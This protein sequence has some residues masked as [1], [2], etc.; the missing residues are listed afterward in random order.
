MRMILEDGDWKCLLVVTFHT[1]LVWS[2]VNSPMYN[3]LY[4]SENGFLMCM[5]GSL[6]IFSPHVAISVVDNVLMVHQTD[7]QVVLLY[8]I[9]T[10]PKGPISAPL[11]L[12]LRGAPTLSASSSQQSTGKGSKRHLSSAELTMYGEGWVFINPDLVLDHMHGLLWRVRLDLE[13][14]WLTPVVLSIWTRLF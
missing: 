8:D 4:L 13:V 7:S 5:Q 11:P 10:D 12:L 1:K 6:P 14:P 2:S 9:L 3:M